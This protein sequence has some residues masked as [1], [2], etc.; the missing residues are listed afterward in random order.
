[1]TKFGR[2]KSCLL[3]SAIIGSLA[4]PS[5]A[6]D[7]GDFDGHTLFRVNCAACHGLTGD[8]DGPVAEELKVKIKPLATLARRNGGAFPEDY[9]QRIIDGREELKAHG[10]KYMPVWG[11]Y[12]RMR[13]QG[14]GPDASTGTI[15]RFL[16]EYIKSMQV[17]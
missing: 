8:G 9:V 5:S 16:V 17:Q 7:K 13:H 1:M 15:I 11:T 3:A 2:L 10:Y 14:A 12:Y 6:Q 4:L